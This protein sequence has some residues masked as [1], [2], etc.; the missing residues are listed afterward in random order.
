MGKTKEGCPMSKRIY[1][2]S[3]AACEGSAAMKMLLGGKGANLAEMCQLGLPV[4]P[5]FTIT[6]EACNTYRQVL[7]QGKHLGP[8][9]SAAAIGMFLD[10]LL[11]EVLGHMVWLKEQ[12]GYMPLVSVRS[13]APISMPGMMD[14]ILNV[15][16]CDGKILAD[17]KD[18]IGKRAALDSYRRLIQMLG[19][20]AYGLPSIWFEQ[21]LKEFRQKAGVEIDA[22]LDIQAL[23]DVIVKFQG[24]IGEHTG[25]PFPDKPSAQLRVAIKTVFDSWMSPRAVEYRKLNK[26]SDAM[27]TAVTVQAMVFG[28]MDEESGTGVLFTRNPLTGLCAHSQAEKVWEPYGEFL[29]NAQGEDVVAGIRTPL[30]LQEMIN[31][32]AASSVTIW[33]GIYDQLC[34]ISQKLEGHYRDMMDVEFTV[35]QG[36][37]WVLQCRVGKRSALAAFRI[38]VALVEEGMIDAAEALS[39]IRPDQ[40]KVVHRPR[41]DAA[42]APAAHGR[43]IPASP[44]VA[45][46]RP[47]FSA[48]AAV[49]ATEPCILVVHETTPDDIAGM[50]KAAGILTTVGG[51]TSHAAVVAR[52]M[53]KPCVVGCSDLALAD[54]Q[55]SFEGKGGF[56]AVGEHQV[57]ICG[58]TGKVWVNVD[59][60]VLDA[61][62]DPAVTRVVGWAL[63]GYAVQLSKPVGESFAY[64]MR[65]MAADWWGDGAVLD[66]VLAVLAKLDR[67]WITFDLT[68]PAAFRSLDDALLE[69]CF[70]DSEV[71]EA[72]FLDEIM[73][74]LGAKAE[75]LAGLNLVVPELL[76][77]AGV[78]E[79]S[80]KN[81]YKLVRKPQTVADL[82][83]ASGAV[84]PD[85]DFVDA[86]IGGEQAWQQ[87]VAMMAQIGK[88]IVVLPAALPQ[89]YVV[90]TRLGK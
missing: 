9:A 39:R 44:G 87:F 3:A 4:P 22:E 54:E 31:Q 57:A 7:A 49:D 61:A 23:A 33:P 10:D 69:R 72:S 48:Q 19:S 64:P 40:Y 70:T 71:P 32:G 51:A 26:I 53:D 80:E 90:F 24:G 45:R 8:E 1:R 25:H 62:G 76:P 55:G 81:G 46:G 85:Q 27:G 18:R 86:V 79:W 37:L 52:A 50:A 41:I 13:G 75:Q 14:T 63:E 68:P 16:L 11:D 58:E 15:G 12:F 36:K 77:P 6:T 21:V 56:D 34:L 2:F 73:A 38:A 47:V 20:T 30:K 84:V 83:N 89:E 78:A 74:V 59:V 35:Q 88:E 17:W 42:H 82:L 28:N 65:V 5:G 67:K 66:Q 60:P 29:V 43:G